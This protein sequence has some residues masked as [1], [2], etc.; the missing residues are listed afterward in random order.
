MPTQTFFRLRDEKQE[1]IMRAAIR[2]FV[3]N[4]FAGAKI[5]DIAAQ[6][7]VAKGSI[8]QYFRDKEE[9]FI[10]CAEW[11]LVHFMEKLDRRIA[12]T[13]MDVFEYF[14]DSVGKSETIAEERE[15]LLFLQLIDREPRLVNASMEAMYA[16]GNEYSKRMI[17]NSQEKGV[18]R[19]DIDADLLF[20]F[21]LA[22]T[23]RFKRRW[24][25]RYV[26]F[27][28]ETSEEQKAAMKE[29]MA[30]MLALLRNG[31]GC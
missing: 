6:A 3:E 21:F 15:L 17:R 29:E 12:V 25:E 22:V 30:Q 19:S 7:G 27:S 13:D 18:V 2:E 28:A 11:G 5:S 31:M 8:Y 14:A 24:M 1:S 26:D 20:E 16:V 4:G 10:Y 23:E 9:L